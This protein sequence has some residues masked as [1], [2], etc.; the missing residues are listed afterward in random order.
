MISPIGVVICGI[1]TVSIDGDMMVLPEVVV[2]VA[3]ASVVVVVVAS[4][5]VVVVVV[6]IGARFSLIQ[7]KYEVTRVNT[8]G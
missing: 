4:V 1:V 6:G 8:D 3:V 2:V 7:S 5:V